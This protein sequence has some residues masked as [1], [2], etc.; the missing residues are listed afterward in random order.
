MKPALQTERARTGKT[1][2]ARAQEMQIHFSYEILILIVCC[3]RHRR[4]R[5]DARLNPAEGT[6]KA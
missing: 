4:L 3:R 6:K 5:A 1:W 2:S